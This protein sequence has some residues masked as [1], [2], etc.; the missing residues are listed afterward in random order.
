MDREIEERQQSITTDERCNNQ[1]TK[2]NDVRCSGGERNKAAGHPS[3]G[4]GNGDGYRWQALGSWW[5]RIRWRL[6]WDFAVENYSVM[7]EYN[8][9]K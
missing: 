1:L 3:D 7:G 2:A 6:K 5:R 4:D 8:F 9:S